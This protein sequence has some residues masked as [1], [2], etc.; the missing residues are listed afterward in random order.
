VLID[1]GRFFTVYSRLANVSV[2][3][4]Q[5]VSMKQ[6]IGTVGP[7][8]SGEYLMHF[9]LWRVGANDKSSAQNPEHWIAR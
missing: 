3:K 9:E 8:D 6:T 7:N 5:T 1:H 2:S 4:G